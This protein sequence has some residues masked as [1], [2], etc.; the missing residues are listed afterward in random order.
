MV[1]PDTV[2]ASAI[3]V[4]DAMSSCLQADLGERGRQT[5]A[6]GELDEVTDVGG[7][8]ALDHQLRRRPDV[9]L[10]PVC[11]PVRLRHG[12]QPVV[13]GVRGGQPARLEAE[14]GQQGIGLD[15]LFNG[16]GAWWSRTASIAGRAF[17]HSTSQLSWASAVPVRVRKRARRRR[18]WPG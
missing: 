12:G 1:S 16:R 14:T 3:V 11:Q 7:R 5:E 9:D 2:A 6:G 10:L 8:R 15:D 4:S 18:R 17:S 13:D